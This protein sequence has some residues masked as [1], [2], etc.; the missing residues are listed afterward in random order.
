MKHRVDNSVKL[1]NIIIPGK[2]KVTYG[3]RTFGNTL[4]VA[5]VSEV[6]GLINLS[7]TLKDKRGTD[8]RSLKEFELNPSRKLPI[9]TMKTGMYDVCITKENKYDK[10]RSVAVILE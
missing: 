2:S 8:V 6:N 9:I 10:A 4:C 5:F 3:T 1:C 7:V